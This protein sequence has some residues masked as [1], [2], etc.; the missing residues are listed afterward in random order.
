MLTNPMNFYLIVAQQ[1]IDAL[2]QVAQPQTATDGGNT[3]LIVA[4]ILIA[5]AVAATAWFVLKKK[6]VIQTNDNHK[7]FAE[8]CRHNHLSRRQRKLLGDLASLQ[9]LT[10]PCQLFLDIEKWAIAPTGETSLNAPGVQAELH[11]LRSLLF[12]HS[13]AVPAPAVDRYL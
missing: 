2:Q 12:T 9:K 3:G 11:R 4:G 6:K 8:L 7:L 5:I 1:R 10:N 13:K